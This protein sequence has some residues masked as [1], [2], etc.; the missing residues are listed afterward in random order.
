MIPLVIHYMKSYSSIWIHA[1]WTT[2]NRV[3]LL[4][5]N[6][7]IELFIQTKQ[8]AEEYGYILDTLNGIEDHMHCLIRLLPDQKLTS[9]IKQIKG[10]SS[11]WINSRDLLNIA[12]AWQAGYGALSVSPSEVHKVR[13]YIIQQEKHHKKWNLDEELERFEY[14]RKT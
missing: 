9:V 2:K 11:H 7:R 10:S 8:N 12:F 3:P 5:K 6:F 13:Q 1:V 4:H 14:Y